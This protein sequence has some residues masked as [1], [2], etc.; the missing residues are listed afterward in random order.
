MFGGG[1]VY[2]YVGGLDSALPK[3]VYRTDSRNKQTTFASR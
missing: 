2:F 1:T 3:D